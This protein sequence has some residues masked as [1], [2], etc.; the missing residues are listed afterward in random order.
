MDANRNATEE[1][2]LLDSSLQENC[3]GV[4][5]DGCASPFCD[6]ICEP[7]PEGQG[8][9]DRTCSQTLAHNFGAP[10]FSLTHLYPMV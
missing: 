2:Q 8:E 1:F 7:F 4:P 6:A 3:Q 10:P 9:D 5:R